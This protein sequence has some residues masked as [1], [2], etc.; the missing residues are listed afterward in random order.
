MGHAEKPLSRREMTNAFA[1]SLNLALLGEMAPPVS[2]RYEIALTSA[3]L[4]VTNAVREG[5][6][7]EKLVAAAEL[8]FAE[9][10][11]EYHSRWWSDE[12]DEEP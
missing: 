9:H 10:A 4:D 12:V 7:T 8:A 11:A 6:P 2:E 5:Q 1:V 3:L